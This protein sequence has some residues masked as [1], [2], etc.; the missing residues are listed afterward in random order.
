MLI[1]I[2]YNYHRYSSTAKIRQKSQDDSNL[3]LPQITK[4]SVPS[5]EMEL[6]SSSTTTG[7]YTWDSARYFF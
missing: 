7:I 5:N 1:I 3:I 6:V 2:F 4:R